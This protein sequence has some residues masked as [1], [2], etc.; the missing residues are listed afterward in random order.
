MTATSVVVNTTTTDAERARQ[1]WRR[2]AELEDRLHI[3]LDGDV[4]DEVKLA[5]LLGEA[6]T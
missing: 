4:D 2:I 3:T 5:G 6:T 1:R